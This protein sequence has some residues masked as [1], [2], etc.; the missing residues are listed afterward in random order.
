[1]YC[2]LTFGRNA[3]NIVWLVLDDDVM[4]LDRN[5]NG[6]LTEAGECAPLQIDRRDNPDSP[7]ARIAVFEDSGR[8]LGNRS[9]D[10]VALKGT[11]RYTHLAVTWFT[12]RESYVPKSEELREHFER[13]RGGRVRVR[14]RINQTQEQVGEAALAGRPKDAAVLQFDG[15]LTF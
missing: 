1:Q 13:L 8:T 4:Y 5:G 3:E 9:A 6:D 11:T 14:V 10:I 12:P 7:L 15:P 2:L